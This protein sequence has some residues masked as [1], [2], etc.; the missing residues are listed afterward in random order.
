VR[1]VGIS[2]L[3]TTVMNLA[4]GTASPVAFNSTFSPYPYNPESRSVFGAA[5]PVCYMQEGL[6]ST[7]LWEQLQG[8]IGQLESRLAQIANLSQ[9]PSGCDVCCGGA[10]VSDKT[11]INTFSAV[12]ALI[13][14]TRDAHMASINVHLDTFAVPDQPR[15]N[16]RL[17]F[18]G[19]N[20]AYY[21]KLVKRSAS[22]TAAGALQEA[23]AAEAA[24]QAALAPYATVPAPTN[25]A[26]P[27][28]S[29]LMAV[30]VP[31]GVVG[32]QTVQIQVPGVGLM[33]VQIPPGLT[34]GQS[35]NVQV[36][37]PLQAAQ[38]MAAVPPPA[39]MQRP[40]A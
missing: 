26:A 38:P 33:A 6:V 5:T 1:V 27:P 32:G 39:V 37:Q 22:Y 2:S 4:K 3:V 8:Q 40:Q 19:S 17:C 13:K 30:Q 29:G 28:A 7:A 9:P 20:A 10:F 34:E 15:D 18:G 11:N 16:V 31:S 21:L 36:P 14:A 35:F 25:L 24:A 23:Q 12:A